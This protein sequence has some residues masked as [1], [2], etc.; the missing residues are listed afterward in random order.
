MP[1]R[2]LPLLL[3][4]AAASS[5]QSTPAERHA[6]IFGTYSSLITSTQDIGGTELTILPQLETAYVIFQCAA[7]DV[8]PPSFV[9]AKVTRSTVDFTVPASASS[10]CSGTYHGVLT[11]KGLRLSHDGGVEFVPRRRSYWAR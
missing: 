3:L 9:P 5:A 8:W 11:A 4:L 7:G 2:W 10:E 1:A 6:P